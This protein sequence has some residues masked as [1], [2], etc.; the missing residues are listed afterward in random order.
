LRDIESVVI[1]PPQM[2]SALIEERLD[3]FCAGEPWNAVAE[4]QRVGKTIAY[5]S[6]VWPDHP[7]KVLACRRDFVAHNP[8]TAAALVQTMLEACRWLD[9]P[10]HRTDMARWLARPEF[11]GVQEHLIAPRLA[12]AVY[13]PGRLPVRFFDDGSVNYPWPS[14]GV[15]F[16]TQYRRWGMTAPGGDYDAIARAVN[17]TALYEAAAKR[18]KIPVPLETRAQVLIDGRVWDGKRNVDTE[19]F[20][21]RT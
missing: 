16:L 4:S 3:G 11:V 8:N 14:D 9:G 18:I 12:N 2:T 6:E 7:E 21:I 13:A 19:P 15:W 5:T 1:P 17:Q 20:D 10:G